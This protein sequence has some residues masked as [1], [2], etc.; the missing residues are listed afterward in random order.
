M[1]KKY[2]P[3]TPSDLVAILKAWGFKYDRSKGDHDQY[4]G[5]IKGKRRLVSVDMGQKDF[6]DFL[7]KSMV[8]QSGLT[9]VQFY[10]STKSTAKKINRKLIQP[11][12][13]PP[14]EPV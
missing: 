8:E 5:Y 3:L 13:T 9:R 10:C 6:D 11:N 7:V 1:P 12:I 14:A 2:P 4:E